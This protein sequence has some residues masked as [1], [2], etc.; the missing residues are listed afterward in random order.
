MLR[1][2]TDRDALEKAKS[3]ALET[4]RT[5]WNWEREKEKL[6]DQVL[7]VLKDGRPTPLKNE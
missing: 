3:S 4:A 5:K 7:Q 6:V 1:R 2:W